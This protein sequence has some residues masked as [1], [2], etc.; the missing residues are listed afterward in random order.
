MRNR[1]TKLFFTRRIRK[2]EFAG[3]I[4]ECSGVCPYC[5]RNQVFLINYYDAK[6]CLF[7]NQWLDKTCSDPNC[8]FCA[9]RPVTPAGA[10]FL[11]KEKVQRNEQKNR[12]DWLRLHYQH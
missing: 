8:P 2:L 5:G 9:N 3:V 10:F 4:M 6:G 12:K 7:C 11:L 1:K